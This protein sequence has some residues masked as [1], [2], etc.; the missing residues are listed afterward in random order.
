MIF[1]DR[2]IKTN[3]N[4]LCFK[5]V[6]P[7]LYIWGFSKLIYTKSIVCPYLVRINTF[8]QNPTFLIR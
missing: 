7:E 2:I 6:C 5:K 3:N 4:M 8:E 1:S